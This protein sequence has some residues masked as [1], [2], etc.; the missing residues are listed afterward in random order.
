MRGTPLRL[1][2]FGY[3]MDNMKA[4]CWYESYMPLYQLADERV[5]DFGATVS[6]LVKAAD[7]ARVYL[8][9]ALKEAWFSEKAPGRKHDLAFVSQAFW[10]H[11]EADFYEALRQYAEAPQTGHDGLEASLPVR[12]T[13]HRTLSAQVLALFDQ[14]A[15]S[16]AIAHGN[17]SRIARAHNQLMKN[18]NGTKLCRTTLNIRLQPERGRSDVSS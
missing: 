1:H 4:R 2:A 16:E 13:W 15:N 5:L 7:L 3:D 14:W 8:L 10:Q 9:G 17:P 11:T 18:L 6:T 12:E